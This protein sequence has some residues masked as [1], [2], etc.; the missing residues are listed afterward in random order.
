M[1]TITT[2]ENGKNISVKFE[3]NDNTDDFLAY[4]NFEQ[5]ICNDTELD[6]AEPLYIEAGKDEDN[7]VACLFLTRKE[8]TLLRDFIDEVLESTK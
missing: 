5:S 3:K 4:F 2:E 7:P 6:K 1:K 8:A